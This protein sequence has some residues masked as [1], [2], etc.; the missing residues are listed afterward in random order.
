MAVNPLTKLH[1][2]KNMS[3]SLHDKPAIW[4]K[5][6]VI[7]T[8]L[9]EVFAGGAYQGVAGTLICGGV[10]ESEACMCK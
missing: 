5:N 10:W 6:S 9:E 4:K 8:Y 2:K 3:Q 1:S 7:P